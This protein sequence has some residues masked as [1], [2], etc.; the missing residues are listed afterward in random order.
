M[1]PARRC[2]FPLLL[3]AF[4]LIAGTPRPILAQP[5]GCKAHLLVGEEYFYGLK[6]AIDGAR[7]NIT[8]AIY[9]FKTS[10][11]KTNRATAIQNALLRAMRR[12][13]DITVIF[14]RSDKQQDFI[15]GENEKTGRRLQAAGAHVFWDRP[16]RKLHIKAVVIDR[17]IVFL[18][19]HNLTHSALKYN[20]EMSLMIHSGRIA[21]KVI[22]RLNRLPRTPFR[23]Q[24]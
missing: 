8:I 19:S 6:D 23:K 22:D 16:D 17:Q 11:F 21:Q 1:K 24:E 20:Q 5:D 10:K 2:I 14:E 7:S 13:V 4:C 12:G 3:L 15:S 18:G 9:L